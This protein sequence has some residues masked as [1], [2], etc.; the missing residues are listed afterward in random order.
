MYL[1]NTTCRFLLKNGV[2]SEQGSFDELIAQK[3]GILF[4]VYRV[5]E[6]NGFP[7]GLL[8]W[9][10]FWYNCSLLSTAVSSLSLQR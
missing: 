8:S 4:A 1:I 3:G 7:R 10:V 5:T 6:V 9:A 2:V